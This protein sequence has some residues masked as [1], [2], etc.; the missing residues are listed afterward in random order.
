MLGDRAVF[1]SADVAGFLFSMFGAQVR[2]ASIGLPEGPD[3][4]SKLFPFL[5]S[6]DA[7]ER[8]HRAEGHSC[9]GR[10]RE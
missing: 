1:G 4:F 2:C 5:V 6:T 8:K 3:I 10:S 7:G 9:L